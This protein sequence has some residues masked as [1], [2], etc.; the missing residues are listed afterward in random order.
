[1]V[2]S[3]LTI[4]DRSILAERE[5]VLNNGQHELTN[6][7]KMYKLEDRI[8]FIYRRFSGRALDKSS[9]WWSD[10]KNGLKLRNELTHP[11]EPPSITE[12]KIEQ[13][14][15]AIVTAL[16]DIYKAVYRTAYPVARRGLDSTLTF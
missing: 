14:F 2:R 16:D 5:F 8:Q 4:L 10:L 9:P 13:A 3:D 11:K 1:M 6:R 12:T 7:L 15:Q